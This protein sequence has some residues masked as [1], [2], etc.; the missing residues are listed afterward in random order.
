VR[1]ADVSDGFARFLF[2]Q[3]RDVE[4]HLR[5]RD[6]LDHLDQAD[7]VEIP[8]Q[9]AEDQR[10]ADHSDQQHHVEEG[11]H[12]RPR[13]FGRNIGG[14][15]QTCRLGRV[16]AG[17]DQQERQRRAELSV[18]GWIFAGAGQHQQC[19]RQDGEA[20]ELQQRAHPD[21]GNATPAQH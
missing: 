8:Q 18:D 19:E 7:L 16:H 2:P 20:A 12:A 3:C 1:E 6:A 13:I 15:R 10:T 4:Q 9:L 5:D 14:Q 17:A 11:D 21:I